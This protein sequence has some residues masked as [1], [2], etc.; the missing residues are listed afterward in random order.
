LAAFGKTVL[1]VVGA[2]GGFAD[3]AIAAGK[4]VGGALA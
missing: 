3:T 2:D 1:A 4:V